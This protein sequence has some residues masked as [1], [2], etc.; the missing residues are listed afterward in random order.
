MANNNNDGSKAGYK[1]AKGCIALVT[2]SSGMCGARLVEMLLERGA[3]IVIAFDIASP[4]NVPFLA[5]RFNSIQQK[6]GGR[7]IIRSGTD[8]DIT[9]QDSVNGAFQC[10]DRPVDV[11]FHLAALVGPFYDQH[12]Y[13][14]VNMAGTMYIIDA[15]KRY[16]CTK[17]VYSS[18]P[19]T[20]MTGND[21]TGQT[22]DELPIAKKFL[23]TYAETKALGEIEVT[24]ACCS[25]LLTVSVAPHQ[26]YGP[27]DNLFLNNLLSTAGTGRLRIFGSGRSIISVCYADNYAHG[28]LCGADA[29]YDDS[30]ALGKFYIVTDDEPQEF[31][32]MINTAVMEC[33]YTDLYSKFH[34]PVWLLYGV[35]Y[36]ANFIGLV[37]NKKFKLNP[38]NVR[39]LTIH[40]YFS[41]K[42]AKRDLQYVP[43]YTFDQAWP[44]TIQWFK[45]YWLPE[46]QRNGTIYLKKPST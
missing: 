9:C 29:L 3:A 14:N 46:F 40:R 18:S 8:G 20:R 30:P 32:K 33:G 45:T 42:N 12:L 10:T 31:W 13:Y 44:I 38:F 5:D 1:T 39:M 24:K 23:A 2:G 43:L 17:L 16:K 37:L 21:I 28:L 35:A 27:Y 36:V 15:C 7:I 11:C 25:T 19:S 26:V 22:E 4:S 41:I 34:L 6:T